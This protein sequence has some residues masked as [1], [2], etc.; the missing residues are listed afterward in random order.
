MSFEQIFNKKPEI[1]EHAH[2]RVNLIGEHTDYTGGFVMPTLLKFKI[3]V[4][5]SINKEKKYHVFSESFKEEKKFNDFIKSKTNDWVDYVK[6]CLFVFYDENKNL[7]NNYLNIF[8]SSNIPMER[9]ISSSSALCVAILKSLNTLFQ[10][11]FSNKHI[12]ILAQK[13]ERDYIGVSGGIMDQMVSAIG[14]NG[15]AFFLDCLSLKYELLNIPSEWVFCLID[16]KIKRNL[17][18]SSYNERY[19]ELKKAE[20]DIKVEYLGS[21]KMKDFDENKISNFLVR[22]RARHVVSEN[23]RVLGAKKYLLENNID[24]FGKLMNESHTSYS[25]DF[26]ASTEDVDIITQRS[27][28]AGAAGSRLTGGGFGGFT[29]SLIDNNNFNMWHNKMEKYYTKEKIFR[30]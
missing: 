15:K 13:V 14:I 8:I 25:K 2:A 11:Q 26:E 21:L 5:I 10:S 22:N 4:E 29:V 12:A 16:S 20:E 18:D 6:G 24:R 3:S 28:E 30:I 27:V 17:R 23:E 7:N 1:K 19:N 9:G